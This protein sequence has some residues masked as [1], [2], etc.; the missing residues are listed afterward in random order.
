MTTISVELLENL[1]DETKQSINRICNTSFN[2]ELTRDYVAMV[3]KPETYVSILRSDGI[4]GGVAFLDLE[5][6][7]VDPKYAEPEYYYVHSIAISQE[8]RGK[9]LCKELVKPL[10]KRFGQKPMYLH[11][12]TTLGNPNV[13]AIKCYKKQ[14][15]KIVPC[16]NVDR[17][18]GPN[19]LMIR[20]PRGHKTNRKTRGKRSRPRTRY[21]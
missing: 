15:F 8:F 20:I 9:G 16:V 18:D 3:Q 2:S 14:G 6:A 5:K 19:S 4:V 1:S 12:R 21:R 17:Q 13:S 7:N 11:V 10:V